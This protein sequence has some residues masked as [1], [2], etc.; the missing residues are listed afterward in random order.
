MIATITGLVGL[1]RTLREPMT[2]VTGV[3]DG[4]VKVAEICAVRLTAPCPRIGAA[5]F[6]ANAT[7]ALEVNETIETPVTVTEVK[8]PTETGAVAVKLPCC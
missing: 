2:A 8:V 1:I 3:V 5:D 6:P 7:G 4:P